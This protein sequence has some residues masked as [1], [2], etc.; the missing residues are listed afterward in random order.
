MTPAAYKAFKQQ[1]VR[2]SSA[3]AEVGLSNGMCQDRH[4][5]DFLLCFQCWLFRTFGDP[6]GAPWRLRRLDLS[7]NSLSDENLCAVLDG[8]K[9]QDVR[10]GAPSG[11]SLFFGLLSA[12]PGGYFYQAVY[13]VSAPWG[14]PILQ[15]DGA[16][17]ACP[18]DLRFLTDMEES[19]TE[20][21]AGLRLKFPSPT[22]A[23]Y[24]AEPH[25][26]GRRL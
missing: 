8:L 18:C 25:E 4:V 6:R 26:S 11:W 16:V 9:S 2:M 5:N 23:A 17:A 12:L 14:G 20:P 1:A 15:I 7:R 3:G 21:A 22:V 24:L 10:A 13:I 19:D